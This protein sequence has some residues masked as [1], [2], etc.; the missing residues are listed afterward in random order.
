MSHSPLQLCRTTMKT[1][2]KQRRAG[3]KARRRGASRQTTKRSASLRL[4]SACAGGGQGGSRERRLRPLAGGH[5]PSAGGPPRVEAVQR[6][7]HASGREP[8]FSCALLS[9]A[10]AALPAPALPSPRLTTPAMGRRHHRLPQYFR[11]PEMIRDFA[12]RLWDCT[13]GDLGTG[14]LGAGITS[15][16]LVNVDSRG[17]AQEWDE[18]M[19]QYSS[20]AQRRRA[21]RP[22]TQPPRPSCGSHRVLTLWRRASLHPQAASSTSSSATIC[23]R[24]TATTASRTSL[25]AGL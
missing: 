17:D 14:T 25:A 6:V 11:K 18:V 10:G 1:T 13:H 3:Q 4:G 9:L 7:V 16:L 15:E 22:H 20:G 23:T 19:G 21:V 12:R 24:C 8:G 2:P 5:E